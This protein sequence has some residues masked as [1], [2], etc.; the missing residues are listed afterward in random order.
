M[1]FILRE[2][3]QDVFKAYCHRMTST[4]GILLVKLLWNARIAGNRKSTDI[5]FRRWLSSVHE[6]MN[7]KEKTFERYLL[8]EEKFVLE[9]NQGDLKQLFFPSIDSLKTIVVEG[10]HVIPGTWWGKFSILVLLFFAF[11]LLCCIWRLDDDTSTRWWRWLDAWVES[12]CRRSL[13]LRSLPWWRRCAWMTNAAAAS[14]FFLENSRQ[15]LNADHFS[16]LEAKVLRKYDAQEWDEQLMSDCH[17]Q[18]HDE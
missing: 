7:W 15:F 11:L 3:R 18:H 5:P 12:S 10:I 8:Q 9:G 4:V 17:H 14:Q 2:E 1:S 6:C 16:R 13:F